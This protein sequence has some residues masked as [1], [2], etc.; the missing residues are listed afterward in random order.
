MGRAVADET[1]GHTDPNPY[2]WV[3]VTETMPET[4]Q[5]HEGAKVALRALTNT[6]VPGATTQQG[7][8]PIYMRYVATTMIGT[9]ACVELPVPTPQRVY[10]TLQLGDLVIVRAA[11]APGSA[12]RIGNA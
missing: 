4:L 7:I 3:T 12:P 5:V 2:T 11:S 9:N 6:G 10:A 8:F 1:L